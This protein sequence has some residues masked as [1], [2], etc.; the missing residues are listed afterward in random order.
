MEVTKLE[1][2]NCFRCTVWKI[3]EQVYQLDTEIETCRHKNGDAIGVMVQMQ[4]II[5][6][7]SVLEDLVADIG[8]PCAGIVIKFPEEATTPCRKEVK[9]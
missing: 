7:L 6:A 4:S 2:C 9:I 8:P 1:K 3:Q 5:N